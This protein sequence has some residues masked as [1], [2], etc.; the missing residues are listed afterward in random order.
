MGR[1]KL[2]EAERLLRET[3]VEAEALGDT[4]IQARV[5]QGIAVTLTTRGQPLEAIPHIWRAVRLFQD[6]ISRTR[7]LADLGGLLLIV[8]ETAGAERALVEAVRLGGEQDYATNA[9]IELMN[10]AAFRRDRLSFE[11]WRERCEARRATMPPNIL[12]DFT[13]K[14]GIGLARFGQLDRA[15]AS[16][17][18]ALRMAEQA[19]LHEFVFRIERI[20]N[21]LRACTEPVDVPHLATAAPESQEEAVREVSAQLAELSP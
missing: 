15:E 17:E 19:R 3:L 21:G 11:R 1:G 8:G 16:L 13:L 5:R 20:K 9:L 2:S 14:T 18:V 10:C 12:V 7:A 6:A 4:D